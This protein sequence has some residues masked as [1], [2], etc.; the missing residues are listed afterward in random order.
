MTKIANFVHYPVHFKQFTQ[1]IQCIL[2]CYD[3]STK[4]LLSRFV[5]GFNMF[6]LENH[7]NSH[8]SHQLCVGFIVNF[9]KQYKIRLYRIFHIM[10]KIVYCLAVQTTNASQIAILVALNLLILLRGSFQVFVLAR[11]LMFYHDYPL[12]M[13]LK[14]NDYV[15]SLVK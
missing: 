3:R 12:Q 4:I 11:I 6:L 1:S 2:N 10:S 8:S 14:L 9:Q 5:K 13:E 7:S 15:R